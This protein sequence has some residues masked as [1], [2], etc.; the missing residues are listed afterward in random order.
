VSAP[1]VGRSHWLQDAASHIGVAGLVIVE[2]YLGDAEAIAT[3]EQLKEGSHDDGSSFP[4]F[5]Q[6]QS[7]AAYVLY[8]A[9]SAAL[10]PSPRDTCVRPSFCRFP[11]VY[12]GQGFGQCTMQSH[13]GVFW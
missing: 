4:S 6:T 9:P 5:D 8:A 1:Y 12:Q 3:G 11:F 13:A 10:P 7:S 2:G